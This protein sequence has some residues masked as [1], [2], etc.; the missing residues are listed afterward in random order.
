MMNQM[1]KQFFGFGASRKMKR[2][3]KFGGMGGLGGFPG[4]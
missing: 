3:S 1:M 2:M 4:M